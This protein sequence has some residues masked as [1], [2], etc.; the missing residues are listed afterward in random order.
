LTWSTATRPERKLRSASRRSWRCSK[1]KP[2]K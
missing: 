1:A 2:A